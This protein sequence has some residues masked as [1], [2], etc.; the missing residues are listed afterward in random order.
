MHFI[1]VQIKHKK[2]LFSLK[3]KHKYQRKTYTI[4]AD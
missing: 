2:H 1:A 3:R 4:S